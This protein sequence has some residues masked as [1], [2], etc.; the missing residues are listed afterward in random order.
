[1]KNTK[2]D[3]TNDI[4]YG[5]AANGTQIGSGYDVKIKRESANVAIILISKLSTKEEWMTTLDI[6]P[7]QD[8]RALACKIGQCPSAELGGLPTAEDW[9]VSVD[10]WNAIAIS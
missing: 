3:R 1:M 5:S 7:D 10:R 8:L 2:I 6:E 9:D 4:D